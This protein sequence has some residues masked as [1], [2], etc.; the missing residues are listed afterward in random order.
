MITGGAG[1]IGSHLA[2]ALLQVGHEVVVIDDL[3]TGRLENIRH[4]KREP[5]FSFYCESVLNETVLEPL[6]ARSDFI[7]H[8]ASAVGVRMLVD[9]PIDVMERCILATQIVLRQAARHQKRIL[10]ASS[11]EVYGKND[12]L[13]FREDA[14]LV[15]GPSYRSRWSYACAKAA[16]EFWAMAY[17]REKKLRV[18]IVRLF[19]TVG[20]RQSGRY[21]MVLP[22]FAQQ[23]LSGT[24]LTVYGDGSQTRCFAYVDDV[25]W[26]LMRLMESD[27]AIGQI[28]N[29]GNDEEISILALAKKVI[30]I[31]GSSST[32]QL[33]PFEKAYARGFE[34]MQRR[35]PDLQKIRKQFGYDPEFNIDEI[36]RR[37][38][39]YHAAQAGAPAPTATPKI[40]DSPEAEALRTHS[41][42]DA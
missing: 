25:V 39:A 26:A 34:D 30:G 18:I 9:N 5:G 36:V 16:D 38:C 14:D 15:F 23:A 37:V 17:H 31:A 27:T 20:P 4:L 1:F 40:V 29:I 35:I 12:I 24:P 11:S 21:G 22:R 8:L 19:N 13:P 33:V 41:V 7:Y 28:Y 10:F 2:E 32:I 3:S 42:V 6:I